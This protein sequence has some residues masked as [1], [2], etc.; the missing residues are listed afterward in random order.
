MS[1]GPAGNPIVT[2]WLAE[3]WGAGCVTPIILHDP[4]DAATREKVRAL[5]QTLAADPA[6]G[7]ES[8]LNHQQTIALGG[9]PD[10]DFLVTLKTGYC[11]GGALT[12]ALVIASPQCVLRSS[13]LARASQPAKTSISLTCARL[14]QRLPAFSVCRCL[15]Q[16]RKLYP[17]INLGSL[18]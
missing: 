13:Y 10:A 18:S 17:F 2:S 3:P 8:V 5:L 4:A 16:N 12:G 1:K 15:R 11:N 9:F 6:N 14:L 7:I